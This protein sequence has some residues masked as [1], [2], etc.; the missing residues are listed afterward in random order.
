MYK[1]YIKRLLD[2]VCALIGFPIFIIIFIIVAPIIKITDRGP[3]FY[4]GERLGKNGSTFKMYKFRSMK[5]NAPDIR[6]R[7]GTTFNSENDSRVTKIGKFI[8]KTSLDETAQIINVIKGNMSIIGPRPDLPEAIHLF[9]KDGE[10]KLLLRPGI[11]GYTQ[12]YYRN[13]IKWN[14][15]V[16]KDIYYVEN[17]SFKLDVKIFFKTLVTV[18][19]SDN[20][21][22]NDDCR[23][24]G[25]E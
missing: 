8:R 15:R 14:E 6:N 12:A 4:N 9:E 13:S 17:V 19:K 23:G 18:L 11:A 2:I 25:N 10:R 21:Y 16:K 1:K 3:I 20:V 7:D 22:I 5:V 24:A